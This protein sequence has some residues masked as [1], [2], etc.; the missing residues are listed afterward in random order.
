V[1]EKHCILSYFAVIID[2][3]HLHFFTGF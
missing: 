2:L 1:E 3:F